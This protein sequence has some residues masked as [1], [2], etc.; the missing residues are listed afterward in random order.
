MSLQEVRALRETMLEVG[1]LAEVW[2]WGR[3]CCWYCFEL[4]AA[5]ETTFSDSL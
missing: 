4:L 1:E 2:G 5:E 3:V